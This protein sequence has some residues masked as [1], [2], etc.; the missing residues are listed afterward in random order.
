MR[1]HED[2]KNEAGGFLV[3]NISVL[4]LS[5]ISDGVLRFKV[6]G[7]CDHLEFGFCSQ[8][9]EHDLPSCLNTSIVHRD[10]L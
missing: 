2:P 1:I 6:N 9:L 10:K 5:S 4:V 7:G 8:P 3:I